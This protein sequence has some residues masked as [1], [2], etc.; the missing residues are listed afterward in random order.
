[1]NVL[2]PLAV[3]L[4]ASL[5]LAGCAGENLRQQLDLAG[6][7]YRS[8]EA[9]PQVARSAAR[10]LQRAAESL[11]RAE[12]F[13]DYLGGAE[14]ALHYAYLSQ[15]YSDIARQHGELAKHQQLASRLQR[16]HERLRLTLQEATLLDDWLEDPSI[17]LAA[18]ETD[19]GVVLT[20]GDVYFDPGSAGLD[21]S[22][23][24]VLLKL[25]YFLRLHPQ[26]K[27]RIEGYSDSRGS[28]SENLKLSRQRARAV[29]ELLADLGIEARR[30]EQVALGAEYPLAENASARGRAQNRRVEIVFSD[31]QGILPPAR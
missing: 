18:T 11:A 14:D 21:S 16:E 27:I 29:A 22:A 3:L 2:R 30:I 20:L 31:A 6:Q 28:V 17:S 9:D 26:R 8:A 15:R 25:A 23:N 7:S 1:M 12:R 13:A 19:R 24:R 4:M 10:D 5:G